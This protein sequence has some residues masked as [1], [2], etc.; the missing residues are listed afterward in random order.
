MLYV[1]EQILD[2]PDDGDDVEGGAVSAVREQPQ[3]VAPCPAPCPALLPLH[4]GDTRHLGRGCSC[5]CWRRRQEEDAVQGMRRRLAARNCVIIVSVA[6]IMG[7][8]AV[9][10]WAGTRPLTAFLSL[11]CRQF[12][13]GS[14]SRD[15]AR[16]AAR[17]AAV[18]GPSISGR[19]DHPSMMGF[20]AVAK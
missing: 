13:R 16:P 19:S 9:W 11:H 1:H 7:T 8:N 15:P 10:A 14:W 2:A 6:P 17:Q 18:T 3:E 20:D 5:W 12:S 4:Q